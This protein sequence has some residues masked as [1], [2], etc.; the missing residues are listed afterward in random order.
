MLKKSEMYNVVVNEYKPKEIR[1]FK[2][3]P[4][5]FVKSEAGITLFGLGSEKEIKGFKC[6]K[7]MK[8]H[9][10]Q[11]MV[12]KTVGKKTE[13]K[14]EDKVNCIADGTYCL[15]GAKALCRT[16]GIDIEYF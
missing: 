4:S 9:K 1:K 16:M 8:D 5:A 13:T 7:I 6:E 3:I 14:P 15:K 2:G 10:G 11:K 12:Y